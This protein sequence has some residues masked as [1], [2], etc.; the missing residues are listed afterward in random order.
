MLT[1]DKGTQ[2][3]MLFEKIAFL[4]FFLR[5]HHVLN[6]LDLYIRND[7]FCW[8]LK[9]TNTFLFE[10]EWVRVFLFIKIWFTWFFRN[11][12]KAL[13]IGYPRWLTNINS[14]TYPFQQTFHFIGVFI[15]WR[16]LKAIFYKWLHLQGRIV[17]RKNAIS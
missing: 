17:N 14:R 2:R 15:K 16:T 12:I 7:S 11:K 1:L 4:I 9:I 8:E 5:I 13:Q 10:S 6:I 3:I